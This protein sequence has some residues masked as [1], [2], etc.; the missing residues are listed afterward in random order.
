MELY[1]YQQN[2]YAAA[3]RLAGMRLGLGPEAPYR[4]IVASSDGEQ[5]V[6]VVL[7]LC[8]SSSAHRGGPRG[9]H[10]G[11]QLGGLL[12]LPVVNVDGH[13]QGRAKEAMEEER[14]AR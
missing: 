2:S 14:N 11:C 6:H 10:R 8:S 9:C 4:V 3:G 7:L 12:I 5:S 1:L 13:L